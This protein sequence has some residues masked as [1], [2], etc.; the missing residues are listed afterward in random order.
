MFYTKEDTGK[1]LS[2]QHATRCH[3]G[4]VARVYFAVFPRVPR[5]RARVRFPTA[6]GKPQSIFMLVLPGFAFVLPLAGFFVVVVA[7]GVVDV[8]GA[9]AVVVVLLLLLCFRGL[10]F[11]EP[12]VPNENDLFSPGTV[13]SV[14][15]LPIFLT[16]RETAGSA[17]GG[18]RLG[19]GGV[20]SPN[21]I[22]A[23]V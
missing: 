17:G 21:I 14:T 8:V 15:R 9:V 12:A 23:P 18:L 4:N 3:V 2:E 20:K 16:R 6:P 5:L 22:V 19:V 7:G 1:P 10:G 13:I 11:I